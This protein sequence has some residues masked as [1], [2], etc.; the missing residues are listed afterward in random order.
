MWQVVDAGVLSRLED[1][2]W[3]LVEA[4][5]AHAG[6]TA[7]DALDTGLTTLE[8]TSSGSVIRDF[9]RLRGPYPGGLCAIQQIAVLGCNSL[10]SGNGFKAGLNQSAIQ[11]GNPASVLVRVVDPMQEND[12]HLNHGPSSIGISI[13]TTIV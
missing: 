13:Q 4:V 3:D 8:I 2:S 5:R 10:L 1:R 6:S 11:P 7:Q 9:V 12:F